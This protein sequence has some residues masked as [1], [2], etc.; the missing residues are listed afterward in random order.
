[1]IVEMK[2]N[3]TAGEAGTRINYTVSATRSLFTSTARNA[4]K[5]AQAGRAL[6]DEGATVHTLA[7]DATDA[8]AVAQA[9]AASGAPAELA[10]RI[11]ERWH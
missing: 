8:D 7:F 11:V 3:K 5:L 9:G 10:A 6:R 1:M 4:D 2:K